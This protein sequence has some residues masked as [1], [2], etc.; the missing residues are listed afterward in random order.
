M[1]CRLENM[2]FHYERKGKGR[3]LLALHGM[4]LDHRSM[5]APS[6]LFSGSA[7]AGCASILTCPEWE[8]RK[9]RTGWQARTRSWTR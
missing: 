4:P 9:A 3:P 8:K 2:T 5:A 6:S 7:K 1:K